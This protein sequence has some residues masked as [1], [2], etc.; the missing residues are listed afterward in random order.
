MSAS[1]RLAL[2]SAAALV[3]CA[4]A[5]ETQAGGFGVREQSTYFQGDA[6][7]GVAA[8]GDISSMFWNPAAAASLDGFNS[9]SNYAG[10]FA[11]ANEHATSGLLLGGVPASANVG[12]SSLVPASYYTLQL[13]DQLYAGLALNAPFGLTTKPDNLSWAGSPIATTTK[14]FSVDANPVLAYK[15]TP[16]LTIGAGIQVEY[17]DIQL[18]HASLPAALP[19]RY[20]KA[21]D[22]GVGVTAGAIWQPMAGTTLGL[23]YRSAVNENVNGLYSLGNGFGTI[24]TGKVTL[25]DEVTF[26]VRQ[27]ITSQLTLL[28]TV[29]WDRW[30][31]IGN[32][33]ATS[34]LCGGVCETLNLNY[35]DSWFYSLGAEYAYNP[36]L[37]LRTGVGYEI[38]PITDATREIQLPDSNRIHVNFGASYKWSDSLTLNASYSHIFFDDAPFCMALGTAVTPATHCISGSQVL[39]AGSSSDSA[40]VVS[41]GWNYKFYGPAPLEPLK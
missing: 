21:D 24:A 18:G 9:S 15:V 2:A 11:T 32:V 14:V 19:S 13:T 35:R 31:S 37:T 6:Y 1:V 5:S 40:D 8:G 16:T 22:V 20:Y 12:S 38:S 4:A 10:V 33:S 25:P 29:E 41:I 26:S 3:A 34:P 23:G 36:W 39:L 17:F 27:A 7:A 30:S 28:G